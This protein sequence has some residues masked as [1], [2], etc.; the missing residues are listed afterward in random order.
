M[1]PSSASPVALGS[2][3]AN[4]ASRSFCSIP[5]NTKWDNLL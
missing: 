5:A 2:R 1:R 4:S 3:A